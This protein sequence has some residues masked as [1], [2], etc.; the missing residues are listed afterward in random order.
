MVNQ[1]V[2]QAEIKLTPP[3]LG[4]LE[5]KISMQNDQTNVTFIAAQAPTREALESS[6]PRLREMFGEIN[7]NLANVDVG[8]QQAGEP[9][10]DGAADRHDNGTA[11]GH[12]ASQSWSAD[13]ASGRIMTGDGLLDTYA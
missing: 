6:I 7:L 12:E 11:S 13:S 8:H 9:G 5:I 4:P 10:R 1:N 3:N 2:Q